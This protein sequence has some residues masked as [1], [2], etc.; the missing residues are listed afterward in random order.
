MSVHS[1]HIIEKELSMKRIL[2]LLFLLVSINSAAQVH[3]DVKLATNH[4]WRGIEVT[5]GMVFT[6]DVNYT[7]LGGLV[8]LGF[9]GGTNTQGSYKEFNNHL[10]FQ[11]KGFSLAFWDTYNFSIGASYNNKEF[12]NYRAHSTGRFLDAS[13]GYCFGNRLPLS[14]SWSTVIFGRDRNADNTANKYSTFCYAEYPVWVKDRWKVDAGIGGAFALNK[15][16]SKEN[17]YGT[18]DG[19]VHVSL[20]ATYNFVLL[21]HEMPVHAYIMWN[22]QANRA[23][24]QL[25]MQLFTF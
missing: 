15:K 12:F 10:S 17:F 11:Y 25:G 14:L 1:R 3:M 8:N 7:L 21:E 16:G 9:W 20:K 22:P 2:G 18:T 6:G 13:V 24:F 23:F 4:L 5:D 19:I